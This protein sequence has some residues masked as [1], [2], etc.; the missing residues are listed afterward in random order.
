MGK[1]SRDWK[2][3]ILMY[4]HYIKEGQSGNTRAH[5]AS[6]LIVNLLNNL[7]AEERK[8]TLTLVQEQMCLTCGAI[9]K[10][11]CNCDPPD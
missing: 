4:R 8:A 3:R 5:E 9:P 1:A 2:N 11:E 6:G 10:S 7:A